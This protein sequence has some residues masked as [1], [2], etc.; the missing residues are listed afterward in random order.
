[1]IKKTR[2]SITPFFWKNF[3]LYVLNQKLLPEKYVYVKCD[4][5]MDIV[6]CI[7]D[8]VIRGAPVIGIV[9][10]YGIVLAVKQAK[11]LTGTKKWE[12]FIRKVAQCIINT[13]PTAY[14]LSY[15][16]N[17]M[18]NLVLGCSET[19]YREILKIA[20]DEINNIRYENFIAMKKIVKFGCSIISKGAIVLTHC[21]AGMLACG[22]IGTAL[23]VIIEGYKLGKVKYVYVD[24]TR[25]YLQGARL[26]ML[27]LILSGV[28]CSL[29]TD[30]M[31]AFVIK[32][33]KV[34]YIIVGA[35]RIAKNGDTANK[36]GT[37][38]L[39][40]L[41][42]Y[43][44]IPFYVVAPTSSIDTS[45]PSGKYIKIEHRKE[46]EVKYINGK[47]ITLKNAKVFHPAFDITPAK[48]IS[49][50]ITE[51]GIFRYPYNF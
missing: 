49:A 36:I 29:I 45:I 18:Q 4:T 8:M 38:N 24:E 2:Y 16:V 44:K 9:G 20:V 17:R 39:A 47:L 11:K 28:P 15:V 33:K 5:Y 13:R 51:Q 50:I 21:N 23:G 31:S 46:E 34:N 7:K 26:T 22:D 10:G 30:N 35:D 48:L 32:E 14:N 37:Y 1:M 12:K 43:H 41:A 3:S 42:K 27:E 6:R 25:P 40:I 19:N